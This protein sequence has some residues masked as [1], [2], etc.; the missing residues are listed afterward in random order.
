[1]ILDPQLSGYMFIPAVQI[2]AYEDL[3]FVGRA[4]GIFE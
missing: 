1:M 4:R 3:N 2:A